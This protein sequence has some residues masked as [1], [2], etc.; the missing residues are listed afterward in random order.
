[1][2]KGW[3]LCVLGLM[4]LALCG[5]GNKYKG[6][7]C[8]YDET[9]TIV[10]LLD[11][12]NN[13]SDRKKIEEKI[14]KFDNVSS[15]NFYSRDDYA[16]ELG[17]NVEDLDIYDTYVILF[18]S[19]DS[20]GTYVDELS[21]MS[22]VKSAEQSNAK[23]NMSLYNIKS[24][25]KY[26]FTDSDEATESDLETGKYKTKKGVITFTPD[27]DGKTKLLYI[28]DGLLCGDAECNQIFAKSTETCSSPKE[29][30]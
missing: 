12:N 24:F 28:K 16:N 8:N 11:K 27:K 6:Y 2:K 4:M 3:K 21:E 13:E 10:V 15:S 22:G 14:E 5:C 25:G 1:M 20:I 30:K 19:M 26:T 18:S 7:W 29:D 17:G 23:T 9:A